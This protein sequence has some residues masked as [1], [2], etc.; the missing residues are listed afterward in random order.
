MIMNTVYLLLGSN[1]GDSKAHLATAQ[2]HIENNIGKIIKAS[3]LYSTEA[4]GDKSQP[5]FLNQIVIIETTLVAGETINTIFDIEEKMGRKRTLKNAPRIIDIDILFFNREIIQTKKLT[6]PHPE[7][8]NRRFV[9]VPMTEL[10]PAFIHPLLHKN[11]QSLLEDCR[12]T[13]NV[14]KI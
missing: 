12:D 2:T 4:W 14:Q 1:I 6:V 9:L 5:S 8:E 10:S 3:S 13:L 11:M 7:I